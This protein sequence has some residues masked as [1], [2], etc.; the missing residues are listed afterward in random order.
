MFED[1]QNECISLF[2]NSNI[3]INND[4]YTNFKNHITDEQK[5]RIHRNSYEKIRCCENS[6]RRL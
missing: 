2:P 4:D 3:D 6:T 5:K 1:R